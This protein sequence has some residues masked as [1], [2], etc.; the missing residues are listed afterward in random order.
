MKRRVAVSL[1]ALA[2]LVLAACASG[3]AKSTSAPEVVVEQVSEVRNFRMNVQ[4][5]IPMTYRI[6][7]RNPFDH[8]VT[9]VSVEVESVGDSGA[10]SMK[11]VR[12]AFDRIINANSTDEIDFRAWI[13]VQQEDIR[14]DVKNPVMLRGSARFES[15]GGAMRR[16]FV[17]RAQ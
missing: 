16:N 5:G 1:L 17:V 11:R 10:Y 9:L 3:G 12:H 6:T 7:I 2:V 13:Q 8:P 15:S 14:G 4:G